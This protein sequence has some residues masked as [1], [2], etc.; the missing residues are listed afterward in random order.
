MKGSSPNVFVGT[1][2]LVIVGVAGFI[3]IVAVIVPD[4]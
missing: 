4:T 1:E 3:W 2:K